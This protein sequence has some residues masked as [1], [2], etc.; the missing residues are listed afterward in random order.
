MK[1]IITSK[2]APNPI[3]PYSHAVLSGNMLFV[4]GQVG[5]HPQ[6]GEIASDIDSQ[7]RQVMANID[8]ILKDGGMNFS[9]VVKT[10]IF[11]QD[12]K[13]FA[14]VNEI[15]GSNFTGDYP[16]RE[17]VEVSRLPLDVL[18]EISVIAIK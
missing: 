9:N 10:T 15:Y 8:A 14:K 13:D 18:V 5:K 11:L 1:K 6:T 3:G 4:S 2:N 17:T 12:F 16:A 7:T